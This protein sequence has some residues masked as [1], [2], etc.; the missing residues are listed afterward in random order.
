MNWLISL[1]IK[2]DFDDREKKYN[3]LINE[4]VMTNEQIDELF[5][6]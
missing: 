5:K 1:G 3:E 4:E 6:P 2:H